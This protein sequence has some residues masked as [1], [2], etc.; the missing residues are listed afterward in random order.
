MWVD[1]IGIRQFRSLSAR[2]KLNS[3]KLVTAY[4]RTSE[5]E[6][7][8]LKFPIFNS[9]ILFK[10]INNDNLLNVYKLLCRSHRQ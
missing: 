10:N 7:K 8:K 1:L 2:R 5:C 3:S 4:A 9:E 6:N